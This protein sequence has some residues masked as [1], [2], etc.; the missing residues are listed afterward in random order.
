M[1]TRRRNFLA[2]SIF[3]PHL[4]SCCRRR[5]PVD[6]QSGRRLPLPHRRHPASTPSR[7]RRAPSAIAV[8][9]RRQRHHR[10]HPR[11]RN[12]FAIAAVDEDPLPSAIAADHY[13]HS[14]LPPSHRPM[15]PSTDDQPQSILAFRHHPV[16][17]DSHQPS[18]TMTTTTI[19]RPIPQRRYTAIIADTT[20]PIGRHSLHLRPPPSLPHLP[21]A[22]TK[23]CPGPPRQKQNP[24]TTRNSVPVA[25]SVR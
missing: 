9:G 19:P 22:H 13:L 12:P 5:H 8:V 6:P 21:M 23:S 7:R 15:P 20:M 25:V 16:N 10:L 24:V 4:I 17:D 3:R 11:R 14:P 1:A 18:S 2:L